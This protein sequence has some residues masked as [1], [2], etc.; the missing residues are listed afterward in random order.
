MMM[1]P[2]FPTFLRH[3]MEWVALRKWSNN[4]PGGLKI[5]LVH[6]IPPQYEIRCGCAWLELRDLQAC[7]NTANIFI[8]AVGRRIATYR[9][10]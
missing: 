4:W 10:P 9:Y 6:F 3:A 8:V 2:P 5:S 7:G 1:I